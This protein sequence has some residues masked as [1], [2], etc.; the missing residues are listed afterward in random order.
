[1]SETTI[2]VEID[3]ETFLDLP[4]RATR[5]VMTPSTA[6]RDLLDEGGRVLAFSQRNAV[7]A[8]NRDRSQREQAREQET[9][10]TYFVVRREPVLQVLP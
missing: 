9:A 7:R 5:L 1:M 8:V 2:I 6:R 10:T 4:R 3:R